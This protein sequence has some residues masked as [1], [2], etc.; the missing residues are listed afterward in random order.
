[1]GTESQN[2]SRDHQLRSFNNL[3]KKSLEEVL[4]SRRSSC[5]SEHSLGKVRPPYRYSTGMNSKGGDTR[6][7]A[8]R[9]SSD[10]QITAK[11]QYEHKTF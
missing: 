10:E 4:K 11:T 7:K 5:P 2:K 8:S 3:S 9:E 6:R 1:M